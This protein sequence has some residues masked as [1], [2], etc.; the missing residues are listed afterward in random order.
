MQMYC[1]TTIPLKPVSFDPSRPEGDRIRS[2]KVGDDVLISGGVIQGDA[3]R[4][5]R[6]VTLGFLAGG[7]DSYPYPTGATVNRVDLSADSLNTLTGSSTFADVGSEQDALARYLRDGLA[8]QV[9]DKAETPPA[10]DERI[11]NL[12]VRSD[13]VLQ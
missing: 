5:V 4:F 9:F 11:Q 3:N 12:S 10:L 7:G 13:T 1:N 2:L 8:G 6:A